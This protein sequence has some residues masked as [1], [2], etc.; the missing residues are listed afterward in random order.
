MEDQTI[1][2]KDKDNK[3]DNQDMTD[4]NNELMNKDG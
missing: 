3:D 1:E 2:D 4:V